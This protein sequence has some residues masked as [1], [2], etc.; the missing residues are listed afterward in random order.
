[1]TMIRAYALPGLMRYLVLMMSVMGTAVRAASPAP[2]T[3][4]AVEQ[5][6]DA[7]GYAI[8]EPVTTNLNI[9]PSCWPARRLGPAVGSFRSNYI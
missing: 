5:G 9:E 7:P 4:W 8:V 1:M 6:T 2:L 3:G